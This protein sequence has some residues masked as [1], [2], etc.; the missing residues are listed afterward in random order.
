MPGA[1][2]VRRRRDDDLP[3]LAAVLVRV[4]AVDGYPVEG[5]ADPGALLHLPHEL[6]SWTAE[7]AGEPIGQVSLASASPA[8]DAARVWLDQTGGEVADLAIRARLF[9]DSDARSTGA[10]RR[11]VSAAVNHARA[12]G[13]AVAFDVMDKDRAAIRLYERMGAR[14]IGTIVHR[15]RGGLSEPAAGVRR[16]IV[17]VTSLAIS[18]IAQVPRHPVQGVGEVV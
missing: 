7:D 2:T 9:V 17:P 12:L 14:R 4:H 11:L 1:V 15:H 8:D 16:P 6:A 18:T 10:G 13:R 5:V 3:A